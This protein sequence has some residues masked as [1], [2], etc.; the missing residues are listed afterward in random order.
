[1]GHTT[2]V[3][4]FMLVVVVAVLLGAAAITTAIGSNSWVP[5]VLQRWLDERS[6]TT[7]ATVPGPIG[8]VDVEGESTSRSALDPTGR[9][10]EREIVGPAGPTG[11]QGPRGERGVRG[12]IGPVG[13]Q[14]VIGATGEQGLVGAQGPAGAT[15]PVGP[16]GATGPQ[17]AQ[18][19][20]G[21]RGDTGPTGA[22]GPVGPTGPQGPA[23]PQ[24]SAGATGATG[25]QGPAGA[26]AQLGP[27]GSFF[28]VETQR[29][30]TPGSALPIFIRQT[31]SSATNGVSIDSNSRMVVEADGV[32]NIQFSFQITKTSNG[33][34]TAYVWLR[35]NGSDVADSN[36][37]LYLSGKN[38]KAI[39]ALNYYIRLNDGEDAEIMWLS[40]DSTIS[41]LYVPESTTPPM[42]SVPSA[43]VTISK[44]GG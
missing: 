38:D 35:K 15:G 1:V 20:T 26:D 3:A 36:T 18:G 32:Y 42:P 13:P 10:T 25:P 2:R 6:D 17:G 30:T 12:P 27:Y 5:D 28:D 19:P 39:F 24:G 33:E 23:G 37:G 9:L 8:P 31:D 29:N 16:T 41:I 7:P 43:I 44:V 40:A 11:P 14:G 34:S 4:R 22:T 21:P